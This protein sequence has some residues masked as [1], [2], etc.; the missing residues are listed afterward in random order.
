MKGHWKISPVSHVVLQWG[1]E[2]DGICLA[3]RHHPMRKCTVLPGLLA[4]QGPS[5]FWPGFGAWACGESNFRKSVLPLPPSL[6]FRRFCSSHRV[7]DE[8]LPS[9]LLCSVS[10]CW[11]F[12][13]FACLSFFIKDFLHWLSSSPKGLASVK[14]HTHQLEW[15]CVSE[16][17]WPKPEVQNHTRKT[18]Y[19]C[20]GPSGTWKETLNYSAFWN[21][22]TAFVIWN[23][24]NQWKEEFSLI[25]DKGP[26]WD[27]DS[28]SL[29][30]GG[31]L[32]NSQ[33]LSRTKTLRVDIRWVMWTQVQ[34]RD[35]YIFLRKTSVLVD[36]K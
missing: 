9:F 27:L 14:T 7:S 3:S 6:S 36:L 23:N 26:L 2:V 18:E 30:E 24:S 19:L 31:R 33:V 17:N 22:W 21:F 8:S 1:L 5:S 11:D 35:V 28:S 32:N 10:S 4:V 15:F 29:W 25:T 16:A 20:L 12:F 34:L 13:F